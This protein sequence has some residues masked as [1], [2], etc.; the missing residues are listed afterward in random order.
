MRDH[1]S[2][3]DKALKAIASGKKPVDR[4][5]VSARITALNHKFVRDLH[6]G[7]ARTRRKFEFHRF[8]G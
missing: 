4:A 7:Q 8:K 1:D 3:L 5:R 2:K 6:L